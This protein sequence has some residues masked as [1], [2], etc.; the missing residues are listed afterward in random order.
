[1]IDDADRPKWEWPWPQS[2]GQV[3]GLLAAFL[4]GFLALAFLADWLRQVLGRWP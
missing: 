4:L 1:M 2:W 3:F